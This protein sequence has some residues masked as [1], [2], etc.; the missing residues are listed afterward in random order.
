MTKRMSVIGSIQH[1]VEQSGVASPAGG[2]QG[3]QG[4]GVE[5]CLGHEALLFMVVHLFPLL[6]AFIS[7][8]PFTFLTVAVGDQA[9]VV[10]ACLVLFSYQSCRAL[11]QYLLAYRASSAMN[12]LFTS[13]SVVAYAGVL[14]ASGLRGGASWW[15][16]PVIA[17]G[18]SETLPVQQLLLLRLLPRPSDGDRVRE[19]VKASHAATGIGSA[20]AFGSGGAVF[21]ALGAPGVAALGLGVAAAK[22]LLCLAIG[23]GLAAAAPEPS[24]VAAAQPEEAPEEG[25]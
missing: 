16:Y 5:T 4:A 3:H 6:D 1:I 13:V 8:L 18:L 23:A 19:L 21:V 7:R 22:L 24:P 12:Y 14:V 20:A 25:A 10:V 17:T 15:F 9:G 11:G 2:A